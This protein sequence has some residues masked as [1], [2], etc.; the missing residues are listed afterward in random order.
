MCVCLLLW[1][2]SPAIPELEKISYKLTLCLMWSQTKLLSESRARWGQSWSDLSSAAE[3]YDSDIS[4]INLFLASWHSSSWARL[5]AMLKTSLPTR[6]SPALPWKLAELWSE[7]LIFVVHPAEFPGS[8]S[9]LR[10]HSAAAE[11]EGH[12]LWSAI[13]SSNLYRE[14][15]FIS[16]IS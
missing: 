5:F 1:C 7:H 12:C 15:P 2:C 8:T 11:E 9:V 16:N 3:V 14:K 4:E 6:S 10:G 13:K